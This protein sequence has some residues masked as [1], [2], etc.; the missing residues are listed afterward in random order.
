MTSIGTS[1]LLNQI[2]GLGIKIHS[3]NGDEVVAHCP[4]VQNHK[5]GDKKP[6]F[7]INLVTGRFLC[8]TGCIKGNSFEELYTA[9]TGRQYIDYK[10]LIILPEN[11]VIKLPQIPILPLAINNKGCE[12][13]ILHR[14]LSHE[15]IRKWGILY[16]ESINA[17]VIP[18]EQIGYVIRYLDATTT[19]EKYKYVSGT[20]ISNC[21]FGESKLQ[22]DLRYFIILV[23]GSLDA[24]WLHQLGYTNTMAL[25]HTDISNIQ[26]KILQKYNMPVY[27]LMDGDKPGK[28]ATEKL[29]NKL[30]YRFFTKRCYLPDGKDPND[31]TLEE[32]KKVLN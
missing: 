20:K 1:N 28:E 10:N 23:E 31:S 16:W 17:I 8:R 22:F 9:I 21:L 26:M 4:F 5:H 24:I 27:L 32:L 18:L 13:L 6:S 7:G 14:A 19:K 12:Y 15:S 3:I 11:K 2:K 30:N 25:L 29:Y